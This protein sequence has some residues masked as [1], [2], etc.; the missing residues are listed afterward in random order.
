ML[1]TTEIQSFSRVVP[2]TYAYSAPG[3]IRDRLD[4]LPLPEDDETRQEIV[5]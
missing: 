2:M 4:A 5:V 3:S 1:E